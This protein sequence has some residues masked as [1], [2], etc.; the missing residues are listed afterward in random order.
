SLLNL[1]NNNVLYGNSWKQQQVSYPMENPSG[2]ASSLGNYLYNLPGKDFSKFPRI[3][4]NQNDDFNMAT[5]EMRGYTNI[6]EIFEII[7][8]LKTDGIRHDLDIN[9]DVFA[10]DHAKLKMYYSSSNVNLQKWWG[11]LP[12]KS[13]GGQSLSFQFQDNIF[14]VKLSNDNK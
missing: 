13:V 8:F 6:G 1:Q 7:E 5:L 12:A 9:L 14:L 3:L 4:K 11:T 2:L 10:T